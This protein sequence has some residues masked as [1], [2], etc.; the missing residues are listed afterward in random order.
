V[1][2]GA[3]YNPNDAAETHIDITHSAGMAPKAS[4][5]LYNMPD[6]ADDSIIAAMIDIV[7]SNTVDVVNMSFGGPEAGYTPP[8][9]NGSNFTGILGV[10]DDIFAEGNALGITWVAASADWGG[11]D[12]PAPACFSANPPT[13]CGPM[14]V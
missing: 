12:I 14:E 5:I 4:V 7:E 2:G 1:E 9:N 11:K 10:Y 8:Y 13:P 6:L 3:P